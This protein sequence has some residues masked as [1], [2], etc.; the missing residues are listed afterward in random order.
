ME[1]DHPDWVNRLLARVIMNWHWQGACEHI[2]V[3]VHEPD[4]SEEDEQWHIALAPVLQEIGGGPHDGTEVWTPFVFD[5]TDF[6]KEEGVEVEH[7]G[8]ATPTPDL[9]FPR[10]VIYLRFEE[11]NIFMQVFLT[12][13]SGL[14][15]APEV[16]D[17]I[18]HT[19]RH[20]RPDDED[21]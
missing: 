15:Q 12:P 17:T 11:Y 4:P 8:V 13:P 5:C 2:N 7:V 16:L 3:S 6:M 1:T 18:R 10:L 20:K 14:P 21:T 9:P 19:L